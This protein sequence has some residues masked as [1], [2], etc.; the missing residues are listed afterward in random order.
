MKMFKKILI[1]NRGEIA[2][3]VMR[4]CR[5]MGI[6]TVAIFSE[7]DRNSLH[8]MLADEAYCIG[9]NLSTESYLNIDK[10]LDVVQKSKAEAV[11]PGYGFLSENKNFVQALD[12]MGVVFIGATAQNISDMG[13]KLR[14][15]ELMRQAGVPV[16]QGSDG[17]VNSVAEAEQVCQKIGF[18]VIIKASSGGGGKGIRVVHEAGELASAFRA[19]R[20]EGKNYFNDDRVFI[21]QFIQ[22][23]KHIEIQVFGDSH[24]NMVHLF[25]RECSVQR[26]HQKLI[27]ETPSPSVPN[28]VRQR[29]GEVSVAAAKSIDYLGAGTME[30]IF[31]NKSKDFFFMEMNT[32]LQV[33]HPV[34][35]MTTGFDLVQEQ[36]MVAAGQKLSFDQKQVESIGHAIE[37]R[38]CAEDPETFA[39]APGRIRSCRV[40]QGP[41]VRVDGAIYSGYE[42]PIF[43]DPML[44]KLV[45]WGKNRNECVGRLKAALA[46]FFLTGVKSNL[47]LHRAILDHPKFLDG[48]YTTQ[49]IAQHLQGREKK[50][51]FTLVDE[52]AF[53]VAAAIEAYKNARV[54]DVSKQ[55]LARKWRHMGRH[56]QLR[57]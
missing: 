34:T 37:L 55:K 32:R 40:P 27:E 29:M 30:F 8:V 45:A 46:E 57:V 26:R 19:C 21:E 17:T 18:P 12:K 7:A 35:E 6:S 10:V 4:A 44:A 42:V 14:S 54:N 47:P 16:V 33:E 36:I 2:V 1:A 39:P 38:I 31:D 56:R 41:F 20:S 9:G 3:R 22:S 43:Y 11:H 49:F 50:E 23:P 5:M 53:V 28:S 25:E 13:D 24:G 52:D 48:S 51:F 15:R